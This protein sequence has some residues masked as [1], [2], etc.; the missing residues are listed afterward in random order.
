MKK[1]AFFLNSFITIAFLLMINAINAAEENNILVG[2]WK[3]IYICSQGPTKAEIDVYD[4]LGAT[5]RFFASESKYGPFDGIF[6]GNLQQLESIV[7]FEPIDN[8]I[9]GWF[10]KPS[11]SWVSI[12]FTVLLSED[13]LSMEGNVNHSG[14]TTIQLGKTG[15]LSN[16]TLD[17]YCMATYSLDGNVHIPCISV[18]DAF[19]GTTIY[20]VQMQH[21]Q[22]LLPLIWI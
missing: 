21:N 1:W 8:N 2:K 5:F 6:H 16:D 18:P 15:I 14:C 13:G 17:N 11:D 4:N 9:A 3:G 12:G 22:V 7:I 20:D 10:R 19:G